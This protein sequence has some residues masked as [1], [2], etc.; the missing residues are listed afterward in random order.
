MKLQHVIGIVLIFALILFNVKKIKR[1]K[2]TCGDKKAKLNRLFFPNHILQNRIFE[3]I[4]PA[5]K[6]YLCDTDHFEFVN[7]YVNEEHEDYIYLI[8]EMRSVLENKDGFNPVTKKIQLEVKYHNDG[9]LE[10]L[11]LYKDTGCIDVGSIVPETTDKYF[12][13][14]FKKRSW[15]STKKNWNEY[16][17]DWDV[18]WSDIPINRMQIY[19]PIC[20]GM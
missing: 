13:S 1:V 12:D 14:F 20:G 5:L 4:R 10:I 11:N 17:K 7:L 3:K 6:K 19:P 9:R 8:V 15:S 16:K 2:R 18:S